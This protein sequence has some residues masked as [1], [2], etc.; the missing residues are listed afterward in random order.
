V[1]GE[2]TRSPGR[3][4]THTLRRTPSRAAPASS[5][6]RCWLDLTSPSHRHCH[7]PLDADREGPDRIH[8]QLTYTSPRNT[9]KAPPLPPFVA[10]RHRATREKGGRGVGGWSPAAAFLP[11]PSGCAEGPSSSNSVAERAREGVLRLGF[12]VTP[13]VTRS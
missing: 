8:H 1:G 6:N 7:S 10:H 12:G 5:N 13:R 4:A 9:K 11:S 3:H 2:Q